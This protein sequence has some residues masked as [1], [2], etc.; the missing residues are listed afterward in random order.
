MV[1]GE[2]GLGEHP[3]LQGLSKEH[4][5]ALAEL[6]EQAQFEAGSYI[7]REGEKASAF[8]LIRQGKTAVETFAA[9]RGNLTIQTIDAGD[10]LGWSWLLPPQNWR[11]SARAIELVRT[12][13][14]DG[15][16]LMQ[17]CEN[18]HELGFQIFSRLLQ[19]VA[20]RLEA[21][22]IQLLD[23]YGINP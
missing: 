6:A 3:F 8:Y 15:G 11:F 7:F 5:A 4:V 19:V 1:N 23:I 21:T 12:V 2:I 9:Q 20:Q 13:K 10:V 16:K 22:R 17:L 18:D 14:L